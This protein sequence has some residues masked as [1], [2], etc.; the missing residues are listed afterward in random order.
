MN[1]DLGIERYL[2]SPL[3]FRRQDGLP[4]FFQAASIIIFLRRNK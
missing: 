3:P 2:T 4:T 1:G